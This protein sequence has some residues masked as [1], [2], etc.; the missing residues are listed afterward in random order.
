MSID[1]PTITDDHSKLWRHSSTN[2]VRQI[3]RACGNHIQFKAERLKE[4]IKRNLGPLVGQVQFWRLSPVCNASGDAMRTNSKAKK[5]EYASY[6]IP[7]E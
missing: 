6:S 7:D 2:S 5:R 3:Q 4:H 1:H